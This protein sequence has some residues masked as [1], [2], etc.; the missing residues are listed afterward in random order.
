MRGLILALFVLITAC[1]KQP[2]NLKTVANADFSAKG[3]IGILS[4]DDNLSGNFIYSVKRDVERLEIWGPA[5]TGH[6]IIT[7]ADG[8]AALTDA[9]GDTYQSDDIDDLIEKQLGFPVPASSMRYWL[10]GTVDSRFAT[11]AEERYDNGLLKNLEQANWVVHYGDWSSEEAANAHPIKIKAR[12][13]ERDIRISI[14]I[15]EWNEQ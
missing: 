14:K 7:A 1:Q 4:S 8:F 5:G 2:I 15:D 12:D 13:D 10:S 11:I 6:A 9:N 3:R